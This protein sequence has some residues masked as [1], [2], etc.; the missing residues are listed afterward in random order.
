M[1]TD[2]QEASWLKD[3]ILKSGITN[4]IF[5]E[6]N[7][8]KTGL[9]TDHLVKRDMML[10]L[11]RLLER[12]SLVFAEHFICVSGDAQQTKL[13]L[14]NQALA[15]CEVKIAPKTPM[16]KVLQHWTGKIAVGSKDDLIVALQLNCYWA[17]VSFKRDPK[18]AIYQ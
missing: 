5:L 14:K 6:A 11:Q 3:F 15:Y 9:R 2:S 1:Y 16:G 13:M 4:I 7:E 17:D 8:L 10:N 18:Y 12:P